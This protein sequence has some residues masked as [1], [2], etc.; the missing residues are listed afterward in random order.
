[1][2][3]ALYVFMLQIFKKRRSS[4]LVQFFIAISKEEKPMLVDYIVHGGDTDWQL[5]GV[6]V[7]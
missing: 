7:P 6:S 1:M 5:P 4:A 2:D 3:F